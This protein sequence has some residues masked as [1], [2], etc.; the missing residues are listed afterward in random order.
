MRSAAEGVSNDN[1]SGSGIGS[2]S[3]SGIG[4]G[5]GSGVEVA[6]QEAA[7]GVLDSLK[8]RWSTLMAS[9]QT[10][11][12]DT[13]QQAASHIPFGQSIL[14]P[15]ASDVSQTLSQRDTNV[16]YGASPL[17]KQKTDA[18]ASCESQQA[19]P[20]TSYTCLGVTG[21]KLTWSGAGS[22][23]SACNCMFMLKQVIH[24]LVAVPSC[25]L[26]TYVLR[27]MLRDDAI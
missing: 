24:P 9:V 20:P 26:H 7:S 2:G 27:L 19:V 15:R 18:V 11:I 4:S 13:I 14:P 3:G 1:G 16:P 22:V 21:E 10:N 23:T 8:G 25:L 5:S 6:L 12:Q 17:K